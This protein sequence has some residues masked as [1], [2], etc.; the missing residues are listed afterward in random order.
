MTR[1]RA[2]RPD[3][4]ERLFE[5]WEAAVA[6]THDFVS[7]ADKVEIARIVRE[8]YLPQ[9]EFWV[10]VDESDRPL[11]FMGMTG[12][13]VES[14]FIDPA[15]HGR[16]L[17]TALMDHARAVA[18]ELRVDVNAQNEGAVAFYRRLGFQEVG[19]SPVDASGRP[20]PLL[21]FRDSH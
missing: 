9:A 12:S 10:I 13:S 1:I 20:Y 6:A 17:G 8:E 7:P 16:G 4:A 3:E 14:L 5:I 21:H 2:S 18:S 15:F 19:R 11:G